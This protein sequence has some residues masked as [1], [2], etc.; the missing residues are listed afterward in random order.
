MKRLLLFILPILTI[1]S[2]A[3][4]LFGIIQVRF[5]EERLMD[6]LKRKAKAIAESVELSVRNILLNDDLRMANRLV[7][8]F[9]KRERLQGCI[10]YD[11]EGKIL[12]ITE[13]ISKWQDEGK[14]Y[15]REVLAS[16]QP[17]A[18]LEKLEEYSVYGYTLPVLDEE[19]NA[20][21]AVEVIYDTSYVFMRLTDLWKRISLPLIVLLF[22]IIVIGILVQRQIFIMP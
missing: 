6:D 7:E 20:L 10:I 2:I 22:S 9:Q 3:F 15:I 16:K 19:G 12:A 4:V 17:Y 21:G 11:K 5:E 18:G 14:S 1:V 13:R 8:R